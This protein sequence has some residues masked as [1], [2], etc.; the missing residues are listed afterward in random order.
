[1]IAD[2]LPGATPTAHTAAAA[3]P[4]LL[5]DHAFAR[6]LRESHLHFGSF[7][8]LR[9]REVRPEYGVREEPG[10]PQPQPRAWPWSS[11]RRSRAGRRAQ[12]EI[13]DDISARRQRRALDARCGYKTR[14]G[15]PRR[16]SRRYRGRAQTSTCRTSAHEVR[17]RASRKG[18][19]GQAERTHMTALN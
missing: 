18:A 1:M 16:S 11:S 5:Y 19:R 17:R 10:R 8:G 6:K 12:L 3:P 13:E 4:Q 2:A 15:A 7:L 9:Q 14:G